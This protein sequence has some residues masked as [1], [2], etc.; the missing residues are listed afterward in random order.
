VTFF[1]SILHLF[2]ITQD[3]LIIFAEIVI[4]FLNLFCS[5]SNYYKS[6]DKHFVAV[7]SI[8]F[9]FD[10]GELKLLLLKRKFEPSH[11]KWSLMGGFLKYNESLDDGARRILYQLTGLKDIFMEQLYAFG[12]LDRDPGE[13]TISIAYFALIKVSDIDIK[14]AKDH[15]AQ[16]LSIKELP[17]L[18]FDHSEMVQK[19]LSKLKIRSELKPI[20]FELLN[21]KFTLPQL[22]ALYEAIHQELL[23]KRNFRKKIIETGLLDNINEKDRAGSK[24]GAFLYRFN[25]E[26]YEKYAELGFNFQLKVRRNQLIKANSEF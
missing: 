3:Y 25:K 7:D 9:G 23:D 6:E 10:E 1:V 21:E 4:E 12:N 5:M 18:I 13:R 17:N 2:T 14:L 19:A 22:Q 15:G 20:G 11:G 24:K 8:I 26:K 16:W